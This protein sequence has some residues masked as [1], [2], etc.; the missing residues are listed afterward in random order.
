MTSPSSWSRYNIISQ[1]PSYSLFYREVTSA[2]WMQTALM[3]HTSSS[4]SIS[5]IL[6]TVYIIN[7]SWWSTRFT[8]ELFFYYLLPPIILEAA[9]CLHNK[10]FFDNIRAILWS[11][12]VDFNDDNYGENV[13]ATHQVRRC[14]HHCQLPPHRN[15]PC[16]DTG[17][18]NSLFNNF[19]TFIW[20]YEGFHNS[21]FNFSCDVTYLVLGVNTGFRRQFTVLLILTHLVLGPN[22]SRRLPPAMF[23]IDCSIHNSFDVSNN[24]LFVAF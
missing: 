4:Q 6:F 19:T 1:V 8:P 10:H 11:V 7:T 3:T 12:D 21:I 17:F 22:S 9:Y 23:L 15:H 16:L 14:R 20:S 18:H 5:V 2:P 24:K 13:N